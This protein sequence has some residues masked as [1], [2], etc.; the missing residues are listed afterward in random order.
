[1]LNSGHRR[2]ENGRK[3]VKQYLQKTGPKVSRLVTEPFFFNLAMCFENGLWGRSSAKFIRVRSENSSRMSNKQ[4]R[5]LFRVNCA[6]LRREEAGK[7]PKTCQKTPSKNRDKIELARDQAY[8]FNLAMCF[9]N[10]LWGSEFSKVHSSSVGKR[11]YDVKQTSGVT[12]YGE[13]R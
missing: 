10:G 12:F 11:F 8:F 2:Q 9:E 4:V 6:E 5:S 1:M 3:R 7:R 13:L